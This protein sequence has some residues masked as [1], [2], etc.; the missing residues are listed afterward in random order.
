MDLVTR[1]SRANPKTLWFRKL[2]SV[3]QVYREPGRS[4][5]GLRLSCKQLD[6]V[7]HGPAL[8]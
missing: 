1:M 5:P 4:L 3:R 2:C 7:I 8:R 6:T